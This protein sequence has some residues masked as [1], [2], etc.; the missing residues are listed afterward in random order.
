M[1]V[2]THYSFDLW[3]TLIKPNPEFKKKRAGYFHIYFLKHGVFRTGDEIDEAFRSVWA[4]FDRY[5]Q[6]F[7]KAPNPMEMYAML[8]FKLRGSLKDISR[9]E[10]Q[11]LYKDVEMLFLAYPPTLYDDD[12]LPV[13]QELRLRDKSLS[14]LS[15]TSFIKGSTL[16]KVL[17]TLNIKEHFLFRLYSDEIGFS[18]PGEECFSMVH[19]KSSHPK[20]KII[21]VGDDDSTDGIG[22]LYY[23]FDHMIIN[24]TELTIKDLL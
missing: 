24:T 4:Y 22:A 5:S 21:H 13:L 18:K 19:E 16:D 20:D 11:F 17:E 23:G 3:G 9:L 8:I 14:L 10:M 12:T 15:N 2:Y 1:K 6:L 7:N